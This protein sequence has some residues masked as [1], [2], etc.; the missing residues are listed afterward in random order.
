MADSAGCV[1][2]LAATA[3][4]SATAGRSYDWKQIETAL[5]VRL[6]SDYKMI[7]ESFPEG[8]FRM[9]AQVWLPENE[10]QLLGDF[11]LDIMDG[12]REL[13]EEE[14]FEEAGF[15]FAAYPEPGGLLLCGSLRVQGWMFWVTGADDP[16]TWPLVLADEEYGDE[17]WERFDGSLCQFLTEVATGHFDA[18]HFKDAYKWHGQESID[19]PSRPVFG[20]E[21]PGLAR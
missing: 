5:G 21:S 2:R 14:D 20:L 4:I 12:V 8:W 7:A 1:R 19:I 16:D 15:P 13:E 10:R 17:H 9:F 11:A 3:G 18:S 6:P